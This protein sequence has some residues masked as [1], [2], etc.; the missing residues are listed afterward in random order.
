[1][2]FHSHFVNEI[3]KGFRVGKIHDGAGFHAVPVATA[4]H[5][6]IP[7]LGEVHHGLVFFPA[8]QAA[9]FKRVNEHAELGDEVVK[10]VNVALFT[11]A[12]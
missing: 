1:M 4:D 7:S 10:R 5:K 6:L 2:P 12:G 8:S 9:K 3:E 11:D